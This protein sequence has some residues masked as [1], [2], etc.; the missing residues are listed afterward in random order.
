MSARL[1]PPEKALRKSSKIP[2]CFNTEISELPAVASYWRRE[3]LIGEEKKLFISLWKASS[4]HQTEVEVPLPSDGAFG[5][6][7]LAEMNAPVYTRSLLWILTDYVVVGHRLS[8]M[9]AWWGDTRRKR[10]YDLAFSD[11]MAVNGCFKLLSVISA[12]CY[13]IG[14]G[15]FS[16][17]C[18]KKMNRG[19]LGDT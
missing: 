11:A 8:R 9:R 10:V 7:K 15:S 18:L 1:C 17:T 19:S 4:V 5:A 2:M 14:L 3:I 16:E 6:L 12:E 13:N